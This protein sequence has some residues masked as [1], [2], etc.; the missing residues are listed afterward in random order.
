VLA[1]DHEVLRSGLR[2]LLEDEGDL[3][4]V[5]E[6]GDVMTAYRL[7]RMHNPDVLVMDLNMPGGSSIKAIGKLAPAFPGTAIVVLTMEEDESFA[8]E[9]FAAGAKAYVLKAAAATA[10]VQAI[11]DAVKR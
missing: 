6:A 3:E 11:R 2:R 9:A 8:R 10:L 5:A 7:V 1:D 4:V